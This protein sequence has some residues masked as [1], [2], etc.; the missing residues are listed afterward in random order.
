MTPSEAFAAVALIAV[1]CDNCLSREESRSLRHQLEARSPYRGF[2]EQAMGQLF[3]GLLTRMREQ[4]W[5][6]LLKEAI[7]VLSPAQQETALA[8]A[9][10]LVLSDRQL[11]DEEQ[12][13][14]QEMASQL[15]LPQGRSQVI[16]DVIGVLN[17]DSLA[18]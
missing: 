5:Q 1:G 12:L 6:A 9:V 13:L 16:I 7:A 10:Q 15:Q 3:D 8:M 17:R 2:T 18:A 14:L 4:G 11:G